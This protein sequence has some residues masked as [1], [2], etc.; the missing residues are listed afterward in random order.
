MSGQQRDPT[1]FAT[2]LPGVQGGARAPIIGGTGNYLAAVYLDGIPVTTIN[3]Q[4][5]NRVISNAIPVEA[6]DQFQVITS[7]A[8]A[9]YQGAGLINF[10]LKSGGAAY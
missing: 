3:Q 1:A 8:G 5:D 6:I 10:T 9:E 7:V 4:G 2:L